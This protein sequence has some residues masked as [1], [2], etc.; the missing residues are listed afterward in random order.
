MHAIEIESAAA[1]EKLRPDWIKLWARSASAGPFQHPDWLLSWWRHVGRGQLWTLEVRDGSALVGLAP[2]FIYCD[3]VRG[4]RQAT[5]LGNGISD[6]C[7]ILVD[8]DVQDV[9]NVVFDHFARRGDRWNC[10]DF[11]DLPVDSPL[12]CAMRERF[13]VSV[14]NDSG[15]VVLDLGLARCSDAQLGPPRLLA[16][17][18]RQRRRARYLGELR[19]KAAGLDD[20]SMAQNGLFAL[21][22]CRW[23]A[24]GES[25]VLDNPS[26][27]AF[28]REVAERFVRS[29]WLRLYCLYFGEQIVAA[30]YGFFLK[31]RAYY[32]IG[33]FDP[34]FANLS[35]A[36]ILLQHAISAAS[37]E[38]ALEFDFLRGG[39]PYK[40]RWGGHDRPQYRVRSP[41][42]HQPPSLEKAHA[43][44]IDTKAPKICT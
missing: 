11:R 27:E 12:I 14:E 6:R 20:L 3:E 35:P 40:Y 38:G 8:P 15:C 25:G 18:R 22:A 10:F 37:T 7:D 19:I 16:D 34:Q 23:C 5:L 26:L 1:L 43:V 2:F 36:G 42:S 17:L 9:E 30:N 31:R 13:D 28:H 41:A 44:S 39:E 4:I 21:H 32:Y 29:G 33:G 24:R